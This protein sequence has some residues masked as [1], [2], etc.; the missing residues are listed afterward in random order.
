MQISQKDHETTTN[1][2]KKIM[3]QRQ[4]SKDCE[5]TPHFIKKREIIANFVK[6]RTKIA[7][8]FKRSHKHQIS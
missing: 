6:N 3:K 8:F 2:P 5:S 1:F 7:I 4:I